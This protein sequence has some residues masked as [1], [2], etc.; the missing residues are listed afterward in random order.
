MIWWAMMACSGNNEDS[1]TAM[2]DWQP[3][4]RTDAW[5]LTDAG[6]DPFPDRPD[7]VDCSELGLQVEGAAFEVSTVDCPYATLRQPL[8]VDVP[9]GTEIEIVLWHLDLWAEEAAMGHI[10]VGHDDGVLYEAQVEIPAGAEVYPITASAEWDM[11]A[12]E[13]MY[14]HV[15][16]H[17]YN[18]WSLGSVEAFT[19]P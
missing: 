10:A 14:F 12:G 2:P 1:G 8:L 16:N 15:H 4:V 11:V 18:S 13:W 17:G 6:D 9:A 5:I 3:M 7:T 19:L